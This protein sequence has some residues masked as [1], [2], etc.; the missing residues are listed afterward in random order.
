MGRDR[1]GLQT[2]LEQ[3]T[4]E[5]VRHVLD[6]LACELHNEGYALSGNTPEGDDEWF[7]QWLYT[8]SANRGQHGRTAWDHLE[9]YE[10]KLWLNLAGL[11]IECLP[12][13]MERISSRYLSAAEAIRVLERGTRWDDRPFSVELGMLFKDMPKD[14]TQSK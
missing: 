11:C 5:S 9:P 4:G 2:A 7:A 12:F 8:V 13:L 3:F 14:D 6:A 1:R 10:Q